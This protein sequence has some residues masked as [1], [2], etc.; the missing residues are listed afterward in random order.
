ME[1]VE[2]YEKNEETKTSSATPLS[3]VRIDF[4]KF[5]I[6]SSLVIDNSNSSDAS[7]KSDDESDALMRN[8]N[9]LEK[10]IE[11]DKVQDHIYECIR[12]A[13]ARRMMKIESG[14]FHIV[15]GVKEKKRIVFDDV[16]DDLSL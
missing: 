9:E 1:P 16:A 13:I 12:H 4:Q 6:P 14:E 15:S 7:D 10:E 3:S 8:M 2:Y 5:I 11:D